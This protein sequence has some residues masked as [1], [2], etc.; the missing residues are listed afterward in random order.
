LRIR[1]ESDI[2][3]YSVGKFLARGGIEMA[4]LQTGKPPKQQKKG[5]TSAENK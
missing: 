4:I 3:P 5:K 2:G 1:H